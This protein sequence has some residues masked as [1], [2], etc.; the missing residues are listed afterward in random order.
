MT[1]EEIED[2]LIEFIE[3]AG[4]RFTGYNIEVEEEPD[5]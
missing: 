1:D 5:D 3:S 2:R 4:S